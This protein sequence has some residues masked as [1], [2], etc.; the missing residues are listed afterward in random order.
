[1]SKL[2]GLFGN[3]QDSDED[4]QASSQIITMF[5]PLSKK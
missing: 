3:Q 1:M 4:G 5:S 2:S